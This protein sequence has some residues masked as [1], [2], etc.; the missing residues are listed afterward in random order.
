MRSLPFVTPPVIIQSAVGHNIGVL[1]RE[2]CGN[3]RTPL[4]PSQTWPRDQNCLT[5]QGRKELVSSKLTT[6]PEITVLYPTQLGT[7]HHDI[8]PVLGLDNI[9]QAPG[10]TD[11]PTV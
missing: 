11:H 7:L 3:H 2:N 10:S 9:L 1:G 4:P 8:L 6:G 5:A